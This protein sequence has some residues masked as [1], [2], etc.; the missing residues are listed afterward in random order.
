MSL[1]NP[2]EWKP[3]IDDWLKGTELEQLDVFIPVMKG[4]YGE[5]KL[6]GINYGFTP[7]LMTVDT[8][9][10]GDR[11]YPA[12]SLE[13]SFEVLLG[14]RPDYFLPS[15]NTDDFLDVF[16]R[17]APFGPQE[18]LGYVPALPMGGSR[19][20]AKLQKVAAFAYLSLLRQI[21]GEAIH[22]PAHPVSRHLSG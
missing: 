3:L 20:Y 4:V 14:V 13:I 22:I 5:F 1:C 9:F 10:V 21:T 16:H 11:E 18:M 12:C 6:F 19:D 2:L 8:G 7:V 17:H 15:S